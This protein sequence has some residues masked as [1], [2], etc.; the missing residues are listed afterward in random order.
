MPATDVELVR[1]ALDGTESA[2]RD[3]VLRYQRPIYGLIARMVRDPSP[4]S[5]PGHVV[6]LQRAAYT[7]RS[8]NF[9]WLY[10]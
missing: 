1:G 10:E 4:R 3:I 8:A 9:G 6:K 7:I 2:F 5:G